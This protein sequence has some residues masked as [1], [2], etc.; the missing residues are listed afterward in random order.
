[1]FRTMS[2]QHKG[3]ILCHW[4]FHLIHDDFTGFFI[5]L[6]LGQKRRSHTDYRYFFF[7]RRQ[8][9][10]HFLIFHTVDDMRRLTNHF[11]IPFSGKLFHDFFRTVYNLLSG[12]FQLSDN[13]S[14]CKCSEEIIFGKCLFTGFLNVNDC[15]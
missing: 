10:H 14:G 6:F 3:L 8:H 12:S 5:V 4:Q 1:M 9:I 2:H 11:F 7:I 15:R 13:H